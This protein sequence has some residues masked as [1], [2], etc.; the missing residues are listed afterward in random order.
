MM[1]KCNSCCEHYDDFDRWRTCPHERFAC[2]ETALM[3]LVGCG[4]MCPRC[5]LSTSQC[6]CEEVPK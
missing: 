3:H 1:L 2:S 5:E 4:L 6:M